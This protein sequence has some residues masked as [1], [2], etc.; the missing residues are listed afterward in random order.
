MNWDGRLQSLYEINLNPPLI[1]YFLASASYIVGWSEIAL[2]L[3]TMVFPVMAILGIYFLAGLLC[4]HPLWATLLGAISPVFL[5]SSTNLMCDVPMMAFWIWA[6]YFWILGNR[7]QKKSIFF[8]SMALTS[9]AIWI[10]FSAINLVPLLS[11]YSLTKRQG[12]CRHITWLLLPIT[13]LMFYELIFFLLYN[14]THFIQSILYASKSWGTFKEHFVV[15]LMTGL[16]FTGG[17]FAVIIFFAHKLMPPR[18]L[19]GWIGAGIA[20]ILVIG[21]SDIESWPLWPK[22]YEVFWSSCI[23]F[24]I[25]IIAGIGLITLGI[26]ELKKTDSADSVLLGLWILGIFTFGT[27]INWSINGRSFLPM[28]PAVGILLAR[29]LDNCFLSSTRSQFLSCGLPVLGGLALTHL[30]AWSE[31]YGRKCQRYGIRNY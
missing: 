6:I 26:K 7:D 15:S 17:C 18:Q 28:T 22:D 21:F 5:T 10:K 3:A 1:A 13:A 30:V 24:G 27:W 19:A 31:P 8:I 20:L 23:H 25:F 12:I 11:V 9:F 4:R 29:R 2:H 14:R 16:S